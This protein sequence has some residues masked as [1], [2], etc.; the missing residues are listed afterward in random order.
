MGPGGICGTA[1]TGT[2]GNKKEL[3]NMAAAYAIYTQ[4]GGELDKNLQ[5]AY[6]SI[7]SYLNG[8]AQNRVYIDNSIKLA[9][10]K[11]AI[12]C[13]SIDFDNAPIF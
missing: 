7:L 11:P 1:R 2:A 4:G 13:K 8:A 10:G 6:N 5:G 3:S 9:A 12:M